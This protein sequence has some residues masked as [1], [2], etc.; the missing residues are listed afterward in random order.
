[1][2]IFSEGHNVTNFILYKKKGKR[3]LYNLNYNINKYKMLIIPMM[4]LYIL[5][6]FIFLF[7][8]KYLNSHPSNVAELMV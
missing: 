7:L 4:D 3:K 1:M 8:G 6:Y 5:T 2:R